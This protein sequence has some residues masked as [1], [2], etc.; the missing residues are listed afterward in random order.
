MSHQRLLL[1][2]MNAGEGWPGLRPDR[3][4]VMG[5]PQ[6]IAQIGALGQLGRGQLLVTQGAQQ[7]AIVLAAAAQRLGI[8]EFVEGVQHERGSQRMPHSCAVCWKGSRKSS[9]GRWL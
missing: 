9:S 2:M 8:L 3:V 4:C 5:V 7:L 1:N 6:Q